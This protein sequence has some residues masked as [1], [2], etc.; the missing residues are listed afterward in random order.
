MKIILAHILV[1]WDG[2]CDFFGNRPFSG[3]KKGWGQKKSSE[4]LRFS[5]FF[6]EK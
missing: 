6:F 4:N 2:Q 1:I 3:P 5:V